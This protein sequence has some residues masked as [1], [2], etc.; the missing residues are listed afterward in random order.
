MRTKL[1]IF[2]AFCCA[3]TML[4]STSCKQEECPAFPEHLVDYY[5]YKVGDM[6]RFVNQNND[7]ISDYVKTVII[8]ENHQKPNGWKDNHACNGPYLYFS[9]SNGL[10]VGD[11][12]VNSF[13]PHY[14]DIEINSSNSIN[15][16][17]AQADANKDPFNPKDSLLFGKTVILKPFP[18][19][20][21]NIDYVKIIKGKGVVEF[22][23]NVDSL[24]WKKID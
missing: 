23:D 10:F 9:T 17:R 12:W 18:H 3:V 20:H 11:I 6:L 14:I 22:F 2:I 16:L 4:L 15:Y 8:T 24:L 21:K 19:N 7:T 1:I 13:E 5:P